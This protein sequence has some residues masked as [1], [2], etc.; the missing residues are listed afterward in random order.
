M[1]EI[2]D[3]AP[4]SLQQSERIQT[5][6][7]TANELEGVEEPD[8]P[9]TLGKIVVTYALPKRRY[10]SR[11]SRAS[12]AM[13]MLE[14]CSDKLRGIPE[15]DARHAEARGLAD[16]LDSIADTAGNCEFPGMYG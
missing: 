11:A 12:D 9:D 7:N 1:R 4:E 15:D 5:L 3:G 10:M 13:L 16:D 2:V 8:V 14:A 6:E